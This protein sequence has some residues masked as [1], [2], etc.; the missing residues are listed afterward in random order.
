MKKSDLLKITGVCEF[1][2]RCKKTLS[3]A[4]TLKNGTFKQATQCGKSHKLYY[5]CAFKEESHKFQSRLYN[6]ITQKADQVKTHFTKDH[7]EVIK[8]HEAFKQECEARNYQR[9]QK[10]RVQKPKPIV[11]KECASMFIDYLLDDPGL[12]PKNKVKGLTD[13]HIKSRRRYLKRFMNACPDITLI[14]DFT[15]DHT[16]IF[17]D[18]IINQEDEDGDRLYKARSYNDHIRGMQEFFDYLIDRNYDIKNYFSD[19]MR[20]HEGSDPRM[21]S[22]QD[23]LDLL[24]VITPE[25]N[26]GRH[27]KK[28]T[29][30]GYF[31]PWIKDA[32]L[33]ALMSGE[34]RDGIFYTTW[35]HVNLEEGYLKIPNFKLLR[36]SKP[37]FKPHYV[38]IT[39]DMAELLIKLGPKESG[40]LIAPE[41]HNRETL[42]ENYTTGFAHFWSLLGKDY[43]HTAYSLRK[44]YVN[45]MMMMIP[46]YYESM[47]INTPKVRDKHY[48]DRLEAVRTLTNKTILPDLSKIIN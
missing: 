45:K 39:K 29:K 12:V 37:I 27:G 35:E 2:S 48:F 31:F 20:E 41:K 43:K 22:D 6:P 25:N 14:N 38:G 4:K 19:N 16:T 17:S 21:M 42:K 33:L 36:R 28:K 3:P 11:F 7:L 32:F 5:N 10:K 15:E 46:E 1:C 8:L 24:S 30:R 26:Y 9:T 40:Y 13:N 44:T 23:I 34:R 18:W 47:G